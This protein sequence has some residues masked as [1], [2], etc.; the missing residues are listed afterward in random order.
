[1]HSCIWVFATRWTVFHC[2]PL[3]MEFSRQEYQSGLPFLT[4][5]DL[6]DPRIK[7]MYLE[8]PALAD[9][10][11]TT[12][13]PGKPSFS[14]GFQFNRWLLEQCLVYRKI[15]MWVQSSHISPSPSQHSPCPP[16]VSLII[17]ILNLYSIFVITDENSYIFI[18]E[19]HSLP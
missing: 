15:E 17:T 1:M 8:Y 13:P 2:V 5:G 14:L 16:R 3:S 10:F 19:I 12:V 18:K 11:F 6:P 9:E 4:P 7:S